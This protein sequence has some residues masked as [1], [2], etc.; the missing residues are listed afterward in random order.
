MKPV[1]PT[2]H[3]PFAIKVS[4]SSIPDRNVAGF[5][6]RLHEGASLNEPGVSTLRR[7]ITQAVPHTAMLLL[8]AGALL[9]LSRLA[10]LQLYQGS[11]WRSVAEG[12]RIRL[13]ALPP[14]RGLVLDRF[15]RTI[16]SNVPSFRVVG[17]AAELPRDEVERQVLVNSYLGPLPT[18]LLHQ[19][20]LTKLTSVSY[21][22]LTF[23]SHLPHDLALRLMSQEPAR[24][25]HV[26]AVGERSYERGAETSHLTGYVG[27]V[28]QA[29]FEGG[30][31][32]LTDT[33]G[34]SGLE[35]TFESVLRGQSGRREVEVDARGAERKVYATMPA[36]SGGT[37]ELSLDRDLQAVAAEA[38]GRAATAYGSG[39]GALVALDP[40][41]GDVLALVS[42]PTFNPNAFTVNRNQEEVQRYLTDPSRPLLNRATGGAYPPGSTI[43]PFLAAAGLAEGVITTETTVVSTGGV[44]LGSQLFA[45]WKAGGHGVTNVYQAIAESV[46]TFFYLLG[47][48]SGDRAGLGISRIT[49]YLQ[50][51]GFG[52]RTGLKL[53]GEQAGFVPSATAK[54]AATGE[55][56]YR[57]DTY[58]VS[59][60]QGSLLVTPLQ[61]ADAYAALATNGTRYVPRLVRATVDAAGQRHE[62]APEVAGNLGLTPEVL[63]VVQ[64]GMRQTVTLGSARSLG[65]LGVEV[66]GKTGTA[67]TGARTNTHGWFAGYL[68][69]AAPEFVVVVLI[70]HGGQGSTVAVPVAREVFAWY[71]R[72]RLG[73]RLPKPEP[74]PAPKPQQSKPLT[75]GKA[76]GYRIP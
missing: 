41:N 5:S 25:L 27:A 51:F 64:R 53:P 31:Y 28:S 16:A 39:A 44:R 63:A 11:Y 47:G 48:G 18:E 71:A 40:R 59:I 57:G 15:G 17:V 49:S 42:Y 50:R 26:E 68:P 66:S 74:T 34:K 10:Y 22:P 38:L 61:L 33:V 70:E 60:G 67:Q 8:A 3:D 20:A 46:N 72:N 14:R 69:S 30:G 73:G 24:G 7:V 4:G 52:S 56:W 75:P 54:L 19:E 35:L 45:D 12:N 37:L 65:S 1:R 76:E 36:V 6:W 32:Q 29:E 55:R 23:A 21:L 9:L 2:H 58:N 62:L 13:E 43:K